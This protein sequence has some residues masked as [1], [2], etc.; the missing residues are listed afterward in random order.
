MI[1]SCLN[2]IKSRTDLIRELL[3]MKHEISGK[4]LSFLEEVKTSLKDV[5]GSCNS[6][7]IAATELYFMTGGSQKR[8]VG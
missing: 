3:E 2:M 1:K 6:L 8:K 5:A 7:S 4:D